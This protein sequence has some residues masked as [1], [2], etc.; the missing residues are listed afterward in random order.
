MRRFPTAAIGLLLSC[1]AA[2]AEAAPPVPLEVQLLAEDP[3]ALARAARELGDPA[4]GAVVFHQG[5]LACTK[6]HHAK[7]GE[8]PIGPD[9]TQAN[10]TAKPAD[11]LSDAQIVEAVI[12]PSKFV[13]KG[14]ETVSVVTAKGAIVT[15]LFVEER[16]DAVV[17]RDSARDFQT[18]VIPKKEIDEQAAKPVSLMPTGFANQLANRQQFLDLARYLLEIS[19]KGPDRERELRPIAALFA[20]P[21]L[22]EYESRVDHAKLISGLDAKSLARDRKSVV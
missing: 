5:H 18:V 20:L 16:P 14:Y 15:G 21:P 22:P 4:R 2:S 10:L 17:L 6:C 12:N 7:P 3:A 9:L 13:R 11:K 19:E 8:K 1:A